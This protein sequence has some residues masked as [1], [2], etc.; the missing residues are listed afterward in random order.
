MEIT[1]TIR[2]QKEGGQRVFEYENALE[3]RLR[4]QT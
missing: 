4:E 2:K 3:F 1:L